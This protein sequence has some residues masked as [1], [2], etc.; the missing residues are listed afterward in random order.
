MKKVLVLVMALIF[1]LSLVACGGEEITLQSQTVNNLTLDIPS[2]FGEFSDVA[3]QIK[4]AINEDSTATITL[5]ERVDAQGVTA[6]LWD[7]ETFVE[8][9]LTGFGDLQVLEFN[10]TVTAAGTTAVYAHYTGKN[11]S[12][13]ETEGHNYFLYFDDGTYQSIAFSYITDKDSSLK[14]NLTAIVDSM[15]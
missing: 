1:S 8:N 13:V 11:S 9:V 4:M 5:S 12:D 3:E 6:D 10:N 7:E 2:D 15:K 14:Q